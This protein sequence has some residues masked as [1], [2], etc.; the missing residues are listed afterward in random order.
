M[1]LALRIAAR[2]LFSKK[3]HS[4]INVISI[5]SV[6]GVAIITA[7]LIC[8]LSVYNG[9]THLIGSL[10]SEIQPDI[11]ILPAS[12]KTLDGNDTLWSEIAAWDDVALL[13]PVIE[14]TALAVY[15]RQLPVVVKGIPDN[16]DE[17]T[18]LSHTIVTGEYMLRDS[19]VSYAIIGAGVAVRLEA[20][21]AYSRPIELYAP[22][23]RGRVQLLRL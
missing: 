14:E 10:L 11:K 16:Y 5:I 22:H 2:Y 4:A 17:L 3:S 6:C 18:G 23:R 7:A 20:G 15:D 12:G 9:F 21:V 13:S 1:V 19:I 8:T